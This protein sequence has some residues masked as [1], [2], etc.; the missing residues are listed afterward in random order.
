M[1]NRIEKQIRENRIFLGISE[2]VLTKYVYLRGELKTFEP[3]EVMMDFSAPDSGIGIL[4][5]GRGVIYSSDEGKNMLMRFVSAGDSV[6]VA[7]MFTTSPLRTRLIACGD[8]PSK[9][10]LLPRAA[11]LELLNYDSTGVLRNNLLTFLSDRISF[12]NGRIACVTGG[13]AERRLALFIKSSPDN[14]GTV[15]IGMSMKAL[16]SA[17]DIGRAS[18]YRAMDALTE[19]GIVSRDGNSITILAPERLDEICR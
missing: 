13:S 4:A 1:A 7:S 16:A 11:F 6:G 14:G 9:I 10:F 5:G 17:L 15:Y 8:I 19:A 18:L 12:L 2:G 3:G